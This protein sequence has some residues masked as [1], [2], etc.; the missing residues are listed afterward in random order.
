MGVTVTTRWKCRV[1][2]EGTADGLLD[3]DVTDVLPDGEGGLW[4][5]TRGGLSRLASNRSQ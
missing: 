2:Y 3:N 4:V 5:A 1:A